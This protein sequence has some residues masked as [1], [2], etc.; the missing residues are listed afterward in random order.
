MHKTASLL[1]L[2][3]VV[4]LL[5]ATSF[6]AGAWW[7][8]VPHYDQSWFPGSGDCLPNSASQVVAW[9][10]G[11]L[12]PDNT[13]W[14]HLVPF[15]AT[16]RD[17][18]FLTNPAGVDALQ[19]Q[20][21]TSMDWWNTRGSIVIS[22]T[23][24]YVGNQVRGAAAAM[25]PQAA[26]WYVDDDPYTAWDVMK[27]A[28]H[29]H[30]PMM[31]MAYG[32]TN[33]AYWGSYT[34]GNANDR[35]AISTTT[36]G[37]SMAMLGYSD[38]EYKVNANGRW[39]I[40]DLGWYRENPGWINYDGV[41]R[42]YTV[43]VRA[44]GT[45]T[46]PP[47]LQVN[48]SANE[49]GPAAGTLAL[50]VANAGS[51]S[52]SWSVS[53]SSDWVTVSGGSRT[54][55][56]GERTTLTV[57]YAANSGSS[58]QSAIVFTALGSEGSPRTATLSQA[59][60]SSCSYAIS[61]ASSSVD[62]AGGSFSVA[63]DASSS[64]C[65]WSASEDLSWV[66]VTPTSATG[67][68]S[69]T[70]TVSANTGPARS[71][72]VVIA[73][74]TLTIDQYGVACSYSVSPTTRSV[75]NTGESFSV[76]V[77]ASAQ[78]C[79]WS[80]SESLSWVSLSATG[81]TGDGAVTVTVDANTGAARSG[82]VTVAGRT[83]SI[84]QAATAPCS[85]NVTPATQ[86]VDAAGASF[87]VS[88]DASAQA[89]AWSASESLSWVGLS[90][91]GGMG[92]GAVTVNVDANTGE[93]RSGSVTVAGRT[94]SISQAAAAPCSYTVTPASQSVDAA[95]ASFS[96]SVDASSQACAWSASESL[97]WVSLSATSGTGDGAVT[98]NMDANTG[99]ARSGSVTIAGRTVSISQAEPAA[100]AECLFDIA[101]TSMT[102]TKDGTSFTVAV[103]ATADCSWTAT[104]SLPWVS[105]SA[106]EGTG[107][108]TVT[109]T[110]DSNFGLVRSGTVTIAGRELTISQDSGNGT[111]TVTPQPGQT[112]PGAFQMLLGS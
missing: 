4:L 108:G 13:T 44:T 98:V 46:P 19:D 66:S 107:G 97:S 23:G 69:V 99:A 48:P 88:V 61:S 30:G 104:E 11:H 18:A 89:C 80:A 56:A 35:V 53:E 111:G 39:V 109:V 65:A 79:V 20:M 64:S 105:L 103:E 101:P 33:Y 5:P 51:G 57:S 58:R 6:G 62:S 77:D 93:A 31:F 15:G 110:V 50:D 54:L 95:G 73:G 112:L 83:V 60:S 75:A 27:A 102:V 76:S 37:H 63:V 45:P 52:M 34:D 92:D 38:N 32:G 59:A 70:I 96:V 16:P 82:S 72:S 68:G 55:G 8:D 24:N 9:H 14:S 43:E 91:T 42:K 7:S 22:P 90:A 41:T 10:D 12:R 17:N 2:A 84:S 36:V 94:V 100:P 78:T 40:V 49:V 87:S 67:S 86:T 74:R 47:V 106:V 81:G 71:G 25:D 1:L 21:K 28:I 26:G 29:N 3:A 85:Y